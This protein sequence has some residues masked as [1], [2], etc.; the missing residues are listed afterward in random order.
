[1]EF[2]YVIIPIVYYNFIDQNKDIEILLT[3]AMLGL[4]MFHFFLNF[5]LLSLQYISEAN[6]NFFTIKEKEE[7]DGKKKK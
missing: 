1:M 2:L 3:F 7:E 6:I 4:S 5:A